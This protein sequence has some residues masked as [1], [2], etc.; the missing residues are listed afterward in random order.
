MVVQ[1]IQQLGGH[2]DDLC[3]GRVLGRQQGC[4]GAAKIC[5]QGYPNHC[6]YHDSYLF[7]A[8]RGVDLAVADGRD[9]DHYPVHAVHV[10]RLHGGPIQQNLRTLKTS[11]FCLQGIATGKWQGTVQ[12]ECGNWL[13][14]LGRYLVA[15]IDWELGKRGVTWLGNRLGILMA[16]SYT[17]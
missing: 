6:G 1:E 10:S 3:F 14:K 17:E 4:D 2:G 7:K 13:Q 9:R 15:E 5:K 8:S 16:S 11:D 12:I